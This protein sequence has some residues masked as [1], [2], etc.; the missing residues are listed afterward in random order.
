MSGT[1]LMNSTVLPMGLHWGGESF[2]KLSTSCVTSSASVDP[3]LRVRVALAL[4]FEP[5]FARG[6]DLRPFLS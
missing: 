3:A 2:R 6:G 5:F 4:D 1:A